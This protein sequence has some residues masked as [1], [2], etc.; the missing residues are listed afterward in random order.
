MIKLMHHVD[1]EYIAELIASDCEI[2]TI[3]AFIT[4]ICNHYALLELDE[5]L[6]ADRA[7]EVA[8]CYEEV[9]DFDF[10]VKKIDLEKIV[11]RYPEI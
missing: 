4:D 6:L 10:D 9:E 3:R 7:R 8:A 11:Q 1:L 5:A 2:D